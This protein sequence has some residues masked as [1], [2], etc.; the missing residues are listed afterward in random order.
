MQ[1][2]IEVL[3]EECFTDNDILDA[4]DNLPEDL[5][6]TYSR[7][8]DRI[9]RH[10][11]GVR[12]APKV[13]T[14]VG[15]AIRPLHI[16]ELRE[17]VAFEFVD[18]TYDPG[19]IPLAHTI[20]NCCAN[21][22]VLDP[23]D[24]CVRFAHPSVKQ[25]LL[26]NWQKFEY[27]FYV[28]EKQG[29]LSCGE[30]CVNY[31]SFSDFGY[32]LQ[33]R[34]R[35]QVTEVTNPL[36]GLLQ[37]PL[38][39]LV[40][41]A[42]R[43]T[44]YKRTQP[45]RTIQVH[46]PMSRPTG[47]PP[48]S[49]KYKF[50]PYAT[51]YWAL[52]TKSIS[53]QSIVW[54]YF[55]DLALRPEASWKIHP[56]TSSGQSVAS[57]LHGLLGWATLE[58]HMP[59]LEIVLSM[60]PGSRVSEF[61]NLPCVEGGL[62]ALHVASR[63]GHEDV[64]ALLLSI[65]SV[66]ALDNQ[67]CTA[68]HHAAVKGHLNVVKLLLAVHGVTVDAVSESYQTPLMLAAASGEEE[69]VAL[70]LRM[71]ANTE[72]RGW[73][74]DTPLLVAA[75]HRHANVV[76]LLLKLGVDVNAVDESGN[77]ALH[78][79]ASWGEGDI[80][81]MLL[82][83]GASL[84]HRD[85]TEWT[86]LHKAVRHG[87]PELVEVLVEAG[88]A[89]DLL[90]DNGD[91]PLMIA[92][93]E[94]DEKIAHL[95]LEH[96][97]DVEARQP[98]EDTILTAA[99]K[100]GRLGIFKLLLEKGACIDVPNDNGITPL[101]AASRYNY[102]PIV[103]VILQK[104]D[105]EKDT[106]ELINNALGTTSTTSSQSNERTLKKTT[107]VNAQEKNDGSALQIASINGHTETARLLLDNGAD[108]DIDGPTHTS[109]AQIGASSYKGPEALKGAPA[110]IHASARGYSDFVEVLLSHGVDVNFRHQANRVS[111]VIAASKEGYLTIVEKLLQNGA[112]VN[113]KDQYGL[114]ALHYATE[115]GHDRVA[116][117]LLEAGAENS[118]ERTVAK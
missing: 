6:A 83:A 19:K 60:D 85:S 86:A 9:R 54:D 84:D 17:A 22:V 74:N 81:R 90:D 82:S 14:W 95:L 71:G 73:L 29:E 61:C 96:G 91:T 113:A 75:C 103:E 76:K 79:A 44:L 108:V 56:W 104:L 8:L 18:N 78:F 7:C 10:R 109:S 55:K 88:A 106:T 116:N 51:Q 67:S 16:D 115:A 20:T 52:G 2:Q 48:D 47:F 114:T 46:L 4:L 72:L 35:A 97:A 11:N 111:A 50:L 99:A 40:S 28:Q 110:L 66:N 36:P 59:L 102:V 93:K 117:R 41:S 25:Y 13:L 38:S 62:P 70:L 77:S 118:L 49:G 27:P 65:C 100:K 68:L 21:L 42:V 92:V 33:R 1:L 37:F 64:V 57:H 69:I 112:E 43:L 53:R 3:W 23:F 26:A 63:S 5:N 101:T 30:L 80:T 107:L 15:Y 89:T 45:K 24:C 87:K 39:G 105:E 12:F 34:P 94:G 31:L 58:R 98:K 32:Q